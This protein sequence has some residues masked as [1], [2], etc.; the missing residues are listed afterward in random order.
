M[1]R[2]VQL[3]PQ[4]VM[5]RIIAPV[6]QVDANAPLG[7]PDAPAQDAAE[8]IPI[9]PVIPMAVDDEQVRAAHAEPV[10]RIEDADEDADE[11]PEILDAAAAA[12]LAE[13]ENQDALAEAA[14][15]ELL[16]DENVEAEAA[17][18]IAHETMFAVAGTGEHVNQ[19]RIGARVARMPAFL[20]EYECRRVARL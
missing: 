2:P 5:S 17:A 12:A 19:R 14:D 18:I 16:T 8:L 3:S 15:S 10:L 9:E 1:L 6:P 20:R 4:A 13:N 7:L 11:E